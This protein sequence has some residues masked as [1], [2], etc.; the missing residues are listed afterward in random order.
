MQTSHSTRQGTSMS[1][2]GSGIGHVECAPCVWMSR[3]CADVA[4]ASQS[5]RRKQQQA[6]ALP[7]DTSSCPSHPSQLLAAGG[8]PGPPPVTQRTSMWHSFNKN[9]GNFLLNV[10]FYGEPGQEGQRVLFRMADGGVDARAVSQ[11]KMIGEKGGAQ[12]SGPRGRIAGTASCCSRSPY[13]RCAR[14]KQ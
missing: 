12:G 1:G 3:K 11:V 13:H 9:Q 10:G 8:C 7:S 2:E 4:A 6:G 5:Q 14:N